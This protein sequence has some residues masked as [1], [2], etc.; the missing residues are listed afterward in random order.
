MVFI[1]PAPTAEDLRALY[2]ESEQFGSEVYSEERAPAVLAYMDNAYRLALAASG[3]S[4]PVSVVELGAGRAWMARAAKQACER[5]LCVAQDVTAEV[6]DATPWADHYF[7]GPLTSVEGEF[8]L[9]SMTHVIEHLV[10]PVSA[11]TQ[12]AKLLRPGGIL[13]VSAPHR[14]EGWS[15][16]GPAPLWEAYAYHHV[17]AHTQYFSETALRLCAEKAGLELIHWDAGHENGQAFEALLRRP[18]SPT[19]APERRSRRF[20]RRL[21]GHSHPSS[22]A[23]PSSGARL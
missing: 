22:S 4:E 16:G 6:R 3:F 2:E 13:F 10:D 18:A 8:H 14:P 9:A 15:P 23:R 17:P 1:T 5:N 19:L 11:L 20:W 7:V 12:V 21:I